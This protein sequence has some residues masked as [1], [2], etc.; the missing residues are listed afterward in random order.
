MVSRTNKTI[1]MKILTIVWLLIILICI[2]EA[3]F[4]TKFED[5]L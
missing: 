1:K 4:C 2:L 5:E 3:Y